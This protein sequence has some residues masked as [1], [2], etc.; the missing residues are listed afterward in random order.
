VVEQRNGLETASIQ[1]NSIVELVF[2]TGHVAGRAR[3]EEKERKQEIRC[4]WGKEGARQVA[5]DTRKQRKKKDDC[6]VSNC[7]FRSPM[8]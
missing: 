2:Q 1:K 7:A 8:T 5:G 4:K 6:G 3:G